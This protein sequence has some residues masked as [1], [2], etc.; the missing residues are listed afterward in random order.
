MRVLIE[1]G[2]RR[3]NDL[4]RKQNKSKK[5]VLS[6]FFSLVAKKDFYLLLKSNINEVLQTKH[7]LLFAVSFLFFSFSFFLP[8][9]L[10]GSFSHSFDNKYIFWVSR[11]SHT[12]MY[13]T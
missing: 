10:V 4:S 1:C 7:F 3:P 2:S 8:P 13:T 12:A 9:F 5:T 11:L 6:M